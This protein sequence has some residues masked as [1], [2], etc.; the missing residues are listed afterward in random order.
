MV[1]SRNI[2]FSMVALF[3]LLTSC[4][5][6]QAELDAT[7]TQGIV[8]FIETQTAKAPTSTPSPVPPT[9]TPTSSPT[10]TPEPGRHYEDEGGFSYIPPDGWVISEDGNKFMTA[11]G[12]MVEELGA[13]INFVDEIFEGSLDD[14]VDASRAFLEV[15]FDE[16]VFIEQ[17]DFLTESGLRGIRQVYEN[18]FLDLLVLQR[19]YFFDTGEIKILAT[20]TRLLETSEEIDALCDESMLT[21]RLEN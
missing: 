17:G 13:N 2:S 21:F 11:S 3:T 4:G 9:P 7:A 18:D 1:N 6:S 19:L 16:I 14:Y 10:A 12:L 5:P 8:Y 20:C 15:F